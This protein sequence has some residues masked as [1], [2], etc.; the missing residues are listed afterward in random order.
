MPAFLDAFGM[1]VPERVVTNEEMAG[2][3]GRT[4]EWIEGATGIR[5]RRW[6]DAATGVAELAVAAARDCLG[7]AGVEASALGLIIVASGSAR[8]GFPGPAAEVALQL[9]LESTPALD[10]PMAS[11]GSL[12]GM[13]MAAQ[14]ASRFGDVLVIG[15]EKMSA[16]IEAGP[17]DANTAMLFGDGAGAA[18]V[19]ARRGRW[20]ILDAVLHT[21]GQYRDS[22][23]FDWSGALRMNGLSVILQ[24]ARKLPSS[25]EEVLGRQK[26]NAAD[27]AIFL[28]HQANQNLLLRV[29]KSLGAPAER[30]YSNV[31]RYGNTSSASMLIAAAEWSRESRTAG[32]VVF[33]AFGAGFHWGALLAIPVTEQ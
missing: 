3:I 32:P 18:L 28:L 31:A 20:E 15:A 19:S 21:D 23:A 7:R 24:A 22:L 9:G 17:L 5:E 11:A 33:S 2:R 6:A 14:M 13:A 10:V 30:V 8:P 16:V 12:F 26:M 4:A 1:H 25:I 27:V 29:A